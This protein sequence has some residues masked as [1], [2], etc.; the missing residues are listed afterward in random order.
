VRGPRKSA[1]SA[2]RNAV[3]RH[4]AK[5]HGKKKR[6]EDIRK[7]QESAPTGSR[8]S[9]RSGS[10]SV[11]SPESVQSSVS[12]SVVSSPLSMLD[13]SRTDP[14]DVFPIRMQKADLELV[15]FCKF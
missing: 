12:T 8:R 15:D 9:W 3:R 4:V 5:Q 2:T 10:G 6:L 1:D 14:F 7:Y 13:A 11:I